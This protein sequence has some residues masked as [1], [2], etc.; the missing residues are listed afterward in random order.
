MKVEIVKHAV[1][2]AFQPDSI[3]DSSVNCAVDFFGQRAEQI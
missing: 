3:S 2:T 1:Q